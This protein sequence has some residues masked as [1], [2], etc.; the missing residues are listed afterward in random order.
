MLKVLALVVDGRD[1]GAAGILEGS[2][3]D[4]VVF[5]STRAGSNVL[6]KG[7]VMICAL[8]VEGVIPIVRLA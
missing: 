6:C 4:A 1:P 7:V 5:A 2:E 8:A 3:T